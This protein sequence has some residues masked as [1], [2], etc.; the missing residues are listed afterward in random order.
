MRVVRY[1]AMRF[2]ISLEGS[3]RSPKR[4]AAAPSALH[5]STQCG[6]PPGVDAAR[7]QRA[8]F[9]GAFPAGRIRLLILQ[10]LMHEGP[11]LVGAGHHAVAAADADMAVHQH[12][13][14]RALERSAGGADID[15][16]RVRAVLAH[17]GN[18]EAR[19]GS[20]V[21]RGDLANPL[22]V[23]LGMA[24]AFPAESFG[25]GRDAGRAAFLAFAG[26]DQKAPAHLRGRGRCFGGSRLAHG[27]KRDAGREQRRRHGCRGL[28]ES[29]P[30]AIDGLAVR[31]WPRLL[32]VSRRDSQVRGNGPLCALRLLRA[33]PRRMALEAVDGD[34]REVVAAPAEMPG[35]GIGY[36][37]AVRPFDGMTIDASGKAEWLAA[38]ALMH[39]LVALVL[40]HAHVIAAHEF[41]GRHAMLAFALG[42]SR[43]EALPRRRTHSPR[44]AGSAMIATSLMPPSQHRHPGRAPAP[45]PGS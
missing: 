45:Y 43:D 7:A 15:A 34:G 11:R 16:R 24:G 38:H 30:A 17:D 42:R 19:A 23:R 31:S 44:Q 9:H 14:V 29:A 36:G 39:G 8:A 1:V 35:I 27:V 18:G 33:G 6:M 21:F 5:A 41:R 28:Q 37:L 3:F 32:K 25:A 13:A 10:R 26:V 40:H 2:A 4:I 12:D 22:R 20:R